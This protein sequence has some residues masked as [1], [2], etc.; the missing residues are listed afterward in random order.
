MPRGA[1]P[2]PSPGLLESERNTIEIFRAAGPSVVYVTNNALR[3]DLFSMNVTEVAQGTGSGFL[4]DAHGHVVT[5]YHV[6]EGG[7]TFSATLPSG[8]A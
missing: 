7:H 2:A 4:W 3:R 6:L 5:N 1:E 8:G